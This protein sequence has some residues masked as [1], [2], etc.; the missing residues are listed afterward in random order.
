LLE[1]FHGFSFYGL[2]EMHLW[3]SN[4]GKQ[5]WKMITDNSQKYGY[6]NPLFLHN[7]YR[8]TFGRY[9]EIAKTNNPVEATTGEFKGMYAMA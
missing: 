4:I 1:S 2:D 7:Q 3:G 5:L 6:K 9:M 8:V